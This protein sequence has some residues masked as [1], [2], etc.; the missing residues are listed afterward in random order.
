MREAFA[1]GGGGGGFD[2]DAMRE[3]M[4]TFRKES[5]EKI[6]AHLSAEQK[7]AFEGLKG[8]KFEMPERAFGF[9]GGRGGGP[10][11]G[12]GDG[13]RGRRGGDRPQRPE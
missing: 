6:L 4:E 2:R 11:G 1:G 5:E 13:G 3:R 12:R 8:E 9:G 10:G 7:T